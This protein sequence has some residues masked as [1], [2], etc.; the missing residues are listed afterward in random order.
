MSYK[1]QGE[2]ST[3]RINE[4]TVGGFVLFSAEP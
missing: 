2:D 1:G 3:L 4:A